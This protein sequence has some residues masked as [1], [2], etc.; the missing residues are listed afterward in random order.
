MTSPSSTISA[1]VK[2]TTPPPPPLPPLP[3]GPPG[4][5]QALGGY[6]KLLAATATAATA[7]STASVATA[8]GRKDLSAMAAALYHGGGGGHHAHHHQHHHHHSAVTAT[9]AGGGGDTLQRHSHSDDDSGCALEEYTWVPAGL[10]P[11]QVSR[12]I[13]LSFRMVRKP[14]FG[15]SVLD[16]PVPKTANLHIFTR[17]NNKIRLRLFIIRMI[18]S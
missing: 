6:E 8:A 14:S 7:T 1:G 13:F 11:D 10:R 18:S 3:T 15:S 5:D 12:L 4:Y 2:R 17:V 9:A 16:V